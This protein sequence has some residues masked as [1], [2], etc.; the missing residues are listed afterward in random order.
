MI[1]FK[2]DC[3][4]GVAVKTTWGEEIRRGHPD[5]GGGWI[6]LNWVE[7]TTQKLLFLG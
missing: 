4:T 1:F 7:G 2:E 5:K 6:F 3:E